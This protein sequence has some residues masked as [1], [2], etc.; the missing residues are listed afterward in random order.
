MLSIFSSEIGLRV[1]KK[2][3]IKSKHKEVDFYRKL[4]INHY[5]GVY[6][7]NKSVFASL[8]IFI[9]FT[10]WQITCFMIAEYIS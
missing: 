4:G 9:F 7:E 8:I 10:T 3:D 2:M 5:R 1:K 6:S